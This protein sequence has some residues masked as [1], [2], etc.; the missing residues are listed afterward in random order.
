M[1]GGEVS[2][3]I[4]FILYL[5]NEGFWERDEKKLRIQQALEQKSWELRKLYH[6][7]ESGKEG[8]VP[9]FYVFEEKLPVGRHEE[10]AWE[11]TIKNI[12]IQIGNN[13]EWRL[14]LFLAS[15]K[16]PLGSEYDYLKM[17][18]AQIMYYDNGNMNGGSGLTC[19]L[20]EQIWMI[21][22]KD[23]SMEDDASMGL[24]YYDRAVYGDERGYAGYP[25]NCRFLCYGIDYRKENYFG[26]EMLKMHCALRCLARPLLSADLLKGNQRYLFGAEWDE[27]KLC[28]EIGRYERWLQQ[29]KRK[30]A[31][32]RQSTVGAGM[33]DYAVIKPPVLATRLKITKIDGKKPI[34]IRRET[35][36]LIEDANI[37]QRR[38]LERYREELDE[39]LKKQEGRILLK[40]RESRLKEDMQEKE[41]SMYERTD[42]TS[43]NRNFGY[44]MM[45]IIFRV[46]NYF[47]FKDKKSRSE[48]KLE[49]EKEISY[50]D[51]QMRGMKRRAVPRILEALVY[52]N[53]CFL[54]TWLAGVDI[55]EDSNV[56]ISGILIGMALTSICVVIVFALFLAGY[57]FWHRNLCHVFYI[58]QKE[59]II[60]NENYFRNMLDYFRLR[61]ILNFHMK[62]KK[63]K[64]MQEKMYD[65]WEQ[66]WEKYDEICSQF[67]ISFG[68]MRHI[69]VQPGTGRGNIRK[70]LLKGQYK[71]LYSLYGNP[72]EITINGDRVVVP[73]AFI[74]E[75]RL[76]KIYHSP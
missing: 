7:P 74:K 16:D 69:A 24:Q 8:E 68:K 75:I 15:E 11:E 25:P 64:S 66:E 27:E 14:L 40:S 70:M 17:F 44:M 47:V 55:G 34:E 5:D 72:V 41:K 4:N 2:A 36:S 13:K 48:R 31:N 54:I 51:K 50:Y 37:E 6:L 9:D 62:Q 20:P 52:I 35:E 43:V 73:F 28:S 59:K 29:V 57:Y 23:T 30:I 63:K 3:M 22:L 61:R 60:S 71:E 65:Q 46:K 45:K 21:T 19:E 42:K 38:V 49:I 67:K 76:V 10:E 56:S 26:R 39:N 58:I 32:I 12:S 1:S 53:L 33:D 18:L